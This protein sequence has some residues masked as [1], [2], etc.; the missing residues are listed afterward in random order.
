MKKIFLLLTF[1]FIGSSVKSIAQSNFPDNGV[2][3]HRERHYAFTNA[4]IYKDYQTKLENASLLI[5]NGKVIT[6]SK[7]AFIP[8]DAVT[9]DCSGKTIYPSFVELLSNYGLP[10]PK[11]AGK[12]IEDGIQLLSDKKG[13]YNW[14]E[15]I[16]PETLAYQ[17]FTSNG[18]KASGLRK[19][20]YGSL[21]SHQ[22]DG[23]ARGTGVLIS[24]ANSKDNQLVL[25]EEASAFYSFKKGVSKQGYPSSLM[26]SIALLKQTHYDAEWYKNNEGEVEENISLKYWNLQ[27]ELPSIFAT[28]NWLNILRADK[29]GDEFGKQYIFKGSGKEYQ[30]LDAIKETGAKLII[31][32]NFPKPFEVNDP[33]DAHYMNLD[34]LKHWELAPYNPGYLEKAGIEFAFTMENLKD[35]KE[36]LPNIK[37]AVKKGLSKETA[38]KALTL[39]PAQII[40]SDDLIGSLDANK[41]ANFIICSGDIFEDGQILE[42]WIQGEQYFI[43]SENSNDLTGLY[44]LKISN[45]RVVY[46]LEVSGKA[47]A[48]DF[49]IVVDDTTKIKVKTKLS[50]SDISLSFLPHQSNNYLRLSGKV[51]E[52]IWEGNGQD[53]L[54]NWIKWSVDNKRPIPEKKEEDKEDKDKAEEKEG[55]KSKDKK[56]KKEEDLKEEP[57]AVCY[58]FLPYGWT[59]EKK[60]STVLFKNA[61]IWTNTDDGILENADLLIRDGKISKVG[62]DLSMSADTVIDASDMHL[63]SG[64]IDEHSHIAISQGVNEWTQASSAE[65]SISDVVNSEDINIYRQLAGGVTTAQLLHGSANPIGGQS[66]IIKFRWGQLPEKMKIEN[67]DGFI[68]F[69]LGENVKHSNWGDDGTIRFPQTRMGV[70]QCFVDHFTQALD[71]KKAMAS[72]PSKT[73][74]DIEMEVL[75]EIINKERFITCHSYVQSEITMLMRVAEQ[76]DF[77]INTF[78]H[79]LEGYKIADKM[80]EH[81]VHAST[82]SDWWMYKFEVNDAIPHNAAIMNEMGIVTAINSDDPE[83][84]RRLNNEAAKG[85]KYGGME[86]EEAWKMVTLNPAK[87]LHLDDQLGSLENGKDADIVLWSGDPLS[88]YSRALQTYVD[89]ICYWDINE[90]EKLR[91]ENSIE[92][93]RLVQ[94][95]I[96]AKEGGSKTQKHKHKE[97]KHYHC[98]DMEVEIR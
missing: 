10:E 38:L 84:A 15:A 73:R 71:Y 47:S 79:I 66:A 95:M 30:R 94:K 74:K 83:M 41:L 27:Q 89:G 49:N 44:D 56:D 39:T 18:E 7:D 72:N 90:D 63:T 4:I 13:A 50:K 64:I 52:D 53:T 65:V 40:S 8:T 88:V 34:D 17:H 23:I 14:N 12:G 3:D 37:L 61:T 43:K 9:I 55:D 86:R 76:F 19:L 58:P 11:P 68:K 97:P 16:K 42:N 69:A 60:P 57:G 82:F 62:K 80:K 75:L 48:H 35:P 22:K 81:G 91:K 1:F 98:D 31:P 67:T 85:V 36:M 20:G 45:Q 70:E 29:I 6:I 77:N 25:R 24:L 54:G 32:V 2:K 51:K 46:Q 26:G 78:T 59:E 28:Q 21:L 5:K 87:I 96:S 33:I 93:N 92:R